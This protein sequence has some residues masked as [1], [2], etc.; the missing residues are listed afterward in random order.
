MY[1]DYDHCDGEPTDDGETWCP[2]CDKTIDGVTGLECEECGEVF[3][4][5]SCA[6]Q[7]GCDGDIHH[8]H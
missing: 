1:D 5:G 3:C 7:Y 8:N 2:I 6:R 4:S